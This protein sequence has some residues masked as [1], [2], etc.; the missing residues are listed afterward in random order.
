MCSKFIV[1]ML[2]KKKHSEKERERHRER[3]RE[4]EMMMT[5]D[6]PYHFPLTKSSGAIK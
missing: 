5:A 2:L 4:R 1:A 6:W 3:G